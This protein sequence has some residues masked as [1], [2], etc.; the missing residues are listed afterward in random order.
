MNGLSRLLVLTILG[1]SLASNACD[2]L[3]IINSKM[4]EEIRAEAA[5]RRYER[6]EIAAEKLQ[7]GIYNR[8]QFLAEL[9]RIDRQYQSEIPEACIIS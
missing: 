4:N 1:H 2:D 9:A 3:D 7:R 5:A 8:E 6:R